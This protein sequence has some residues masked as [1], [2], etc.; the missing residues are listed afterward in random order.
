MLWHINF[1]LEVQLTVRVIMGS[2]NLKFVTFPSINGYTS[3]RVSFFPSSHINKGAISIEG[4]ISF[5]YYY[6]MLNFYF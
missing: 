5:G 2:V 1:C 3:L 6:S 4:S